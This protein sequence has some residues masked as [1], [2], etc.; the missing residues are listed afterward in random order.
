ML[1]TFN[2]YINQMLCKCKAS[3]KA[4]LLSWLLLCDRCC[5]GKINGFADRTG[6]AQLDD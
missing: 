6:T 1:N 5:T 3:I 4:L 2:C